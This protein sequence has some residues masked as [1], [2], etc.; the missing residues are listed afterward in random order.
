MALDGI[1]LNALE[2]ELNTALCGGRLQKVYQPEK[3][4]LVFH[5]HANQ[6]N[7]KLFIAASSSNP[8]LHLIDDSLENPKAPHA[9]CMLLRKH[10]QGGKIYAIKQLGFE[11]IIEIY[12]ENLDE[13]GFSVNKKLVIEIMG[14]HSN[15]ILVDLSTN[16]IL[17]AMKR[18]SFDTSRV[19]QL[20]PGIEYVYPP[21][22]DKISIYDIDDEFIMSRLNSSTDFAKTLLSTIQGLGP[23]Y[24]ASLC[25]NTSDATS[26]INKLSHLKKEIQERAFKPVV[27]INAE[28]IC[29]DFYVFPMDNLEK[30][31][32]AKHF[33]SISDALD[34]HFKNNIAGST[35]KQKSHALT[36]DISN[37]IKKMNVKSE[38]MKLELQS[39]QDSEHLRLYGEL[40]TANLHLDKSGLKSIELT[41]Y[42][43]GTTVQ[44]PLDVRFSLSKNAQLYYKKYGKAKTAVKEISHQLA[45][46]ESDI[47]YLESVLVFAGNADSQEEIDALKYELFENGYIKKRP[48]IYIERSKKPTPLSYTLPSGLK[49]FVGKN[50]KENDYLT[51]KFAERSDIWLHTKDI[52]GSHVILKCNGSSP[53]ETD[54]LAAASIAAF[55]SKAKESENVPVDYVPAKLVKKPAKAKAGMV[56]FTGNRTVYVNPKIPD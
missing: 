44:I 4:E 40:L 30:T 15:A 16:K 39:A 6:S 3:D 13:L 43:D 36:T 47:K 22:Q 50:N 17:D 49:V 53:A 37:L 55:H 19:R 20:L 41:N 42:Y 45:E 5:I 11:R 18:I 26:L 28:N 46:V 2:K 7:Y 21:S 34:F 32:T 52:P 38:K 33:C 14:R 8:R 31:C 27:Y 48:S 29:E 24:A 51:T 12:F 23:M 1:A 25:E 56:I 9:F 35:L 10:I 54:I